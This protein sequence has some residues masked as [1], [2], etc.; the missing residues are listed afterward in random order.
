MILPE[1]KL[2]ICVVRA[3]TEHIL[4]YLFQN[5]LLKK[6]KKNLKLTLIGKES[7]LL[8]FCSEAKN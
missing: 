3:I 7:F 1:F 2:I 5:Y 4:V 6:K 8:G